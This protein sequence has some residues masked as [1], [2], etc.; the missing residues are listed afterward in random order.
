[1]VKAGE[2]VDQTI[3]LIVP[4]LQAGDVLLIKRVILELDK[5]LGGNPPAFCGTASDSIA[6]REFSKLSRRAS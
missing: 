3:Q 4:H 1:M 6:E 5:S 2:V